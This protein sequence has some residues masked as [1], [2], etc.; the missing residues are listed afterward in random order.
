[1]KHYLLALLDRE[2]STIK[3]ASAKYGVSMKQFIMAAVLFYI[4]SLKEKSDD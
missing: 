2:H 4:D 3:T 1:M